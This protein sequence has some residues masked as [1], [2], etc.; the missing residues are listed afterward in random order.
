VITAQRTAP[1]PCGRYT[2]EYTSGMI[3]TQGKFSQTYG[4]FE[5]RAKFPAGKGFQPAFWLLPNDSRATGAYGEIDVVEAYSQDPSRTAPH[6]HYVQT[7]GTPGHGVHCDIAT[8]ETAFHTYAVE[9]TPQ[10]MSFIYDGKPCWSTTWKPKFGFAPLL[11]G[12]PTPFNQPFYAI[13]QLAVGG[14]KT[15]KNRPTDRT[16]F[17]ASMYV[18]YFRVWK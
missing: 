16:P 3:M 12:A 2:T 8:N 1:T 7:P 18:D 14:S 11:A 5:I 4:R 17:P 13:I 6:L 10:L 9:W 15:P